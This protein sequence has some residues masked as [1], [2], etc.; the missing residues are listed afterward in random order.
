MKIGVECQKMLIFI[1]ILIRTKIILNQNL[2]LTAADDIQLIE[3]N[4]LHARTRM[5]TFLLNTSWI[6]NMLKDQL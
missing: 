2:S 6:N 3:P 1:A 4:T 5:V